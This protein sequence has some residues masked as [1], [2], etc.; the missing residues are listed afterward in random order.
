M[1]PSL[2]TPDPQPTLI[3]ARVEKDDMYD[4]L[5]LECENEE[6]TFGISN[7]Q[8][9]CESFG[10]IVSKNGGEYEDVKDVDFTEF[11]GMKITSAQYTTET[12]YDGVAVRVEFTNGT[13]M[14]E[15]YNDHNGYYPHSYKV[16]YGDWSD[17]D[18]L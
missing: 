2:Y 9:C 4:T 15:I 12:R 7:D 1:S 17:E 18:N 14:I 10:I 13:L 11:Q 5:T 16:E 6:F 8:M 3:A